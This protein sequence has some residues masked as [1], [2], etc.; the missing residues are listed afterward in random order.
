MAFIA[1][2]SLAPAAQAASCKDASSG[3]LTIAPSDCKPV[4]KA[5]LIRGVAYAPS[6]APLAVK[7][8]IAA[9]NRIRNMRYV[10]GG[11]HSLSRRLD[12]G[13]DCSGS[14][15]YALRAAGLL[16]YPMPSGSFV[17]W[18]KPGVGRWITTYD[19]GGHMYMVIAGLSFDTSNMSSTGGNR[20][21]TT[22]RSSRGFTAR[23]PAGF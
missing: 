8:A 3:G 4:K 12:R 13:Y 10:Y 14:V 21:S 18:Q 1:L 6:T 19:N 23:H 15:S 22:I 5:R 17:N 16:R 11:G 20:W 7:K 9:A 2:S